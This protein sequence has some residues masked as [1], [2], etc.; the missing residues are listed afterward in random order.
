SQERRAAEPCLINR[1]LPS[2]SSH[3]GRPM[4]F[5]GGSLQV[6]S[7]KMMEEKRQSHGG[8]W[9]QAPAPVRQLFW[10]MRRAV[11]LPKRR[12]VSFGRH[13]PVLPL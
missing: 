2:A 10:R 7:R 5:L 13:E 1:E 4:A 3:Q 8:S 11:L 9:R 6:D 12:A